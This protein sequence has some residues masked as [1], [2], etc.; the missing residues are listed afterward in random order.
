M[1]T[2]QSS[3]GSPSNVPMV[4]PWVPEVDQPQ[5]SNNEESNDTM[6]SETEDSETD[7]SSDESENGNDDQSKSTPLAE[8]DIVIVAPRGRFG[9]AKRHLNSFAK[10]GDSASMKRGV[11]QYITKGYGGANSA[12]KRFGGTIITGGAIFSTLSSVSRGEGV[13][14]F[15]PKD[16]AN[17]SSQEIVDTLIEVVRPVDGTQDTEASR[18]AIKEAFSQLLA[19][20]ENKNLLKLSEEDCLFVTECYISEDVF[21]RFELDVGVNIHKNSPSITTALGRLEE[22]HSYIRQTVASNFRKFKESVKNLTS[23]SI[24]G[25][26]QTALTDSFMVFEEYIQ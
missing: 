14:N 21:R 20:D 12:V 2:S 4:P 9:G 10:H 19:K 15:N 17:K 5:P 23:K 11:R 25:I 6:D 1:G 16:L 22:I 18:N 26:I 3:S 24:V 13:E 7:K 8:N